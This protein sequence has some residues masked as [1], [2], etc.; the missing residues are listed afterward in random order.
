MPEQTDD[1]YYPMPNTQL[2]F[3]TLESFNNSCGSIGIAPQKQNLRAQVFPDRA[4]SPPYPKWEHF[5][6]A[7]PESVVQHSS[8]THLTSALTPSSLCFLWNLI[9]YDCFLKEVAVWKQ[10]CRFLY[11]QII[12]ICGAFPGFS[13]YTLTS[14]INPPPIRAP[15]SILLFF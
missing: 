3:W 11:R 12:I 7:L 15:F 2:A 1:L 13:G 5:K 9:K 14:A 4:F 8:C 10:K 6:L